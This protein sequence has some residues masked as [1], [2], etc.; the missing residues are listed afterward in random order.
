MGGVV[1]TVKKI[2]S[3]AKDVVK[4]P[5]RAFTAIGTMG[6]SELARAALNRRGQNSGLFNLGDKLYTAGGIAL[7]TAGVTGPAGLGM[8]GANAGAAG[9][10]GAAGVPTAGIGG[11]TSAGATPSIA[12]VAKAGGMSGLQKLG[13]VAGGGMLLSGMLNRQH[14]VDDVL[15][16][17]DEERAQQLINELAAEQEAKRT[18]YLNETRKTISARRAE[19]VAKLQGRLAEQSRLELP[20]TLED[21]N[22]RGLFNSE[23]AVAQALADKQ[24]QNALQVQQFESQQQAADAALEDQIASDII[25]GRLSLEQE[26]LKRRF[27]LEDVQA[28]SRLAQSLAKR[29]AAADRDAQLVQSGSQLLGYTL[30]PR[31]LGTA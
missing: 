20:K 26:G 21:L 16:S 19:N 22:S 8:W 25:E 3:T 10:A 29:K 28:Q 9:A 23:S 7:G 4:S 6:G 11:V 5:T 17:G 31:L 14:E 18:T 1:N 24:S 2:G 30:L 12:A 13:M 27:G 15:N